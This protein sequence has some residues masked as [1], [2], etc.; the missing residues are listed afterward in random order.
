MPSS[1]RLYPACLLHLKALSNCSPGPPPRTGTLGSYHCHPSE[2]ERQ[3]QKTR[4]WREWHCQ[5][6]QNPSQQGLRGLGWGEGASRPV[7]SRLYK[8][9]CVSP[10]RVAP[11][12]TAGPSPSMGPFRPQLSLESTSASCRPPTLAWRTGPNR[13]L[14]PRARRALRAGGSMARASQQLQ[15][16]PGPQL[17]RALAG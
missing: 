7:R 8:A 15:F 16:L 13:L 6:F 9:A 2:T 12:E 3:Q 1:C 10:S 5:S 4:R 14:F 11:Q 17:D